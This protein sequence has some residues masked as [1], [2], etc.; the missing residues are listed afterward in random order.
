M[1]AEDKRS[2][3]LVGRFLSV[4]W[5]QECQPRNARNARKKG[6]I[7]KKLEDDTFGFDFGVNALPS[8][9]SCSTVVAAPEPS[10]KRIVHGRNGRTRKRN[11]GQ[12]REGLTSRR[13]APPDRP[14]AS[15]P[16][17][18]FFPWSNRLPS[19]PAAGSRLGVRFPGL[20]GGGTARVPTTKHTKHTKKRQNLEKVKGRYVRIRLRG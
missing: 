3:G 2:R 16:C 8:R 12:P 9:C 15:L 6:K 11:A 17:F 13:V 20:V 18:P 10:L 7:W 1:L 14:P 5:E 4:T 19:C